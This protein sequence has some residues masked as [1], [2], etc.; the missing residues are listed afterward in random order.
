MNPSAADRLDLTYKPPGPIAGGFLLSTK[1]VAGINGPVGSGKTGVNFIKH[2]VNARRQ[3]PSLIDG[4][5]KYKF[6]TVRDTY[7]QMW[8]STLPSWWEWVPQSYGTWKGERDGPASHT[9]PM[10]LP[11][12]TV[13]ELIAEFIAIGE[14]KAEDVLRGYQPTAF[15]LNELDLM[16]EEVFDY[17]RTRT[18]RYPRQIEGG[19]TWHGVT[20]DCNAPEDD[21]WLYRRM[22][23]ERPAEW[24]L[25]VQPGGLEPGAENR[26]NLVGDYYE[27]MLVGMPEWLARRMVHNQVGPSRS[28][29]VVFPEFND[30]RHVAP[31][32]LPFIRGLPLHLGFDAGGNPAMTAG[33]HMPDSQWRVLAEV[34]AEPGTGPRRF[35]REAAR[36]LRDLAPGLKRE[37]VRARCDP[38]AAYG[39]DKMEGDDNWIEIVERELGFAIR[40]A[41]TNKI[42]PRREAVRRNLVRTIDGTAPGLLVSPACPTLRR[43]LNSGFRY[44]KMQVPGDTRYA[45][46][47]EKNHWSHVAEACEYMLLDADEYAEVMGR[48]ERGR[49][50]HFQDRAVTEDDGMTGGGRG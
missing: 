49:A 11:D 39:A 45:P 8:T 50:R 20:F 32:P 10:Q 27:N 7:R 16:A 40:A 5:R 17:C 23:L 9:V 26:A 22:W 29:Q 21:S 44:R 41:S 37:D 34:A 36:V 42:P 2:I 46:E 4:R 28:G 38:S 12:G 25:F 43:A 15:Y 24:D 33:Q 1:R 35:A 48:R 14:H 47:P 31:A 30:R 3:R 6:T 18:G 13:C 19:A